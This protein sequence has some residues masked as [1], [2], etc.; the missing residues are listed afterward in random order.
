VTLAAI[1]GIGVHIAARVCGL[2]GAGEILATRTS[3]DL[4]LGSRLEF[5]ARGMHTLK[6][7]SEPAAEVFAVR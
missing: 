2:A 3:R 1:A 6:G 4:T 7:V 5:E